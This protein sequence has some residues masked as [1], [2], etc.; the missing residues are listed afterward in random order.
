MTVAT[1]M[2]EKASSLLP[3]KVVSILQPG[4]VPYLGFFELMTRSD[5]FVLYDD[6]Q[7]DKNSWR[8]RN[9]I[10]GFQ[11]PIWLTVPV[12]AKGRFGQVIRD[13]EIDNRQNWRRKHLASIRQHYQK[14]QYFEMFF[15]F[16][17]DLYG[18]DW[19]FLI[20]LNLEIIGAARDWLDIATEV[21]LSSSLSAGGH[22]TERIVGICESLGADAYIS[23]NGAQPYLE[24]EM[25][26]ENGI[27]LAWQDY[28]HPVYPQMHK[29]FE[30]NMAFVD[31][32]FNRGPDATEVLL[33]TSKCPFSE[34]GEYR[35]V[36]T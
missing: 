34:K 35:G 1:G 24:V 16:F 3:R 9:R 7:F 5:Q 30:P 31:L 32:L 4:Y 21:I 14:S 25:L 18:Q 36:G 2:S 19:N 11:G 17:D 6:V 29:G 15:P 10:R 22:K 12:L 27:Q 8:N 26:S 28:Q 13:V 23:T 33:S 20:D